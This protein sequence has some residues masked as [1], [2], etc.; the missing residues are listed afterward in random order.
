VVRL[1]SANDA[2]INVVI[3]KIQLLLVVIYVIKDSLRAKLQVNV[4]LLALLGTTKIVFH[5]QNAVKVVLDVLV[6]TMENVLNVIVIT[7]LKM[8][9]V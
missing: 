1:T 4:K 7:S 8:E 5:V 2:F 6:L 9:N 3:V